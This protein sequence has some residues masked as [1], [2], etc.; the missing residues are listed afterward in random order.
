MEV[1]LWNNIFSSFN[2]VLSFYYQ[3]HISKFRYVELVFYKNL[4][5]EKS[6]LLCQKISKNINKSIVLKCWF[7]VL[8][9][10][11]ITKWYRTNFFLLLFCITEILNP[12]FRWT[13]QFQTFVWNIFIFVELCGFIKLYHSF[14]IIVSIL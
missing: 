6:P 8:Y 1:S 14:I 12:I 4:F 13:P 9:T 5:F 10:Q 2:I 3:Y 7:L 11:F